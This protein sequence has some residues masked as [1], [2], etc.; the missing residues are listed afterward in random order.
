MMRL[1]STG[2][3]GCVSVSSLHKMQKSGNKKQCWCHN[4]KQYILVLILI[5]FS[6]AGNMWKWAVLHV[7]VYIGRQTLEQ[8]QGRQQLGSNPVHQPWQWTTWCTMSLFFV[9]CRSSG[10]W[11]SSGTPQSL[12]LY[13]PMLQM[14]AAHSSEVSE[15]SPIPQTANIPPL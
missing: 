3:T 4:T 1:Y 2:I 9:Y 5:P 11:C 13:P 15:H 12:M 6:G 10:M 14:L 8:V 7:L